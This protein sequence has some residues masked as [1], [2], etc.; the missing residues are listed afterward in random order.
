MDILGTVIAPI[1][2]AIFASGGFWSWLSNRKVPNKVISEQIEAIGRKV[3]QIEYKVDQTEA[4]ACRARLLIFN[5]EL[6]RREKHTQEEFDQC[7]YDCDKY[8]K[9]CADHPGFVNNKARLSIENIKRCYAK[10]SE[11]GDFI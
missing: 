1:V 6:V 7:L 8:E 2:V 4:I 3:D 11:D 5:K 9:F 10:C